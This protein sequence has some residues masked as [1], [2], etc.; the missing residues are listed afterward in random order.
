[1]TTKSYLTKAPGWWL[2]P[3]A[4][5]LLAAIFRWFRIESQSLW[6]DEGYSLVFSGGRSVW[7]SMARIAGASG[8]ERF[9]PAYFVL[10]HLWRAVLG[11]AEFWL[12]SLSAILGVVAVVV[13]YVAAHQ[14]LNAKAALLA[15]LG[16]AVS[17]FAIIY[18][19]EVRPYALI[20]LVAAVQLWAAARIVSEP[21]ATHRWKWVL[22]AS[23][24]VGSFCSLFMLLFSGAL[25]ASAWL[26]QPRRF[27]WGMW[28]VSAV[29]LVPASLFY[30][31]PMLEH[32]DLAISTTG[33]PVAQNAVFVAYG[34]LAGPTLGPSMEQ[35]RGPDRV[36][37]MFRHWPA[38]TLLAC[39]VLAV[40]AAAMVSKP[41]GSVESCYLSCVVVLGFLSSTLFALAT[42]LSW[43]PRHSGFLLPAM[44]LAAS[45]IWVRRNTLSRARRLAVQRLLAI[46]FAQYLALNLIALNH[47]YF[48]PAYW[49]D[50]YRAVADFIRTSEKPSVL[51]W[52]NIELLRYYEDDKTINGAD[53]E[54]AGLPEHIW[55][56]TGGAESVHVVINREF[57]WGEPGELSRRVAGTYKTDVALRRPYFSVYRLQTVREPLVAQSSGVTLY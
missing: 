8:S 12:R 33:Q 40:L 37:V 52:G 10:L 53:Y 57:Y 48:D 44:L 15:G 9:Q 26:C 55:R 31:A 23:F 22:W 32:R 38:L 19:Q 16:I 35:L 17:A 21:S 27:M 11:S 24:F 49:R 6:Y 39:M 30:A 5:L 42:G 43:Q 29:F 34:L 45:D 50:D 28:G 3:L 36:R 51:L 7:E 41:V 14:L 25:V 4:L 18:S 56:A 20:V 46:G 13:V 1:M 47:Y 2:A 54:K